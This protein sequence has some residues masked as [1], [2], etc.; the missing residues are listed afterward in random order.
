MTKV[1]FADICEMMEDSYINPSQGKLTRVDFAMLA[2]YEP[3][4]YDFY[5]YEFLKTKKT[6]GKLYED[7]TGNYFIT[8]S[9]NNELVVYS[10]A[11]GAN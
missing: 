9:P 2:L 11:S 1:S 3:H 10:N 4:K 5:V 7:E 8:D 6:E